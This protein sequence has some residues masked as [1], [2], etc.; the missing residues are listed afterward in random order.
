METDGDEKMLRYEAG[1]YPKESM[2]GEKTMLKM[3]DLSN[4]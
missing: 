4:Y 3:P 1:E 2:V